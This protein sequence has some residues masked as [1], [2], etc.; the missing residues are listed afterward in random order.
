MAVRLYLED[1]YLQSFEARI[2]ASR[3][4]G[5][6]WEVALD[7]TCFYPEGGGQPCDLGTLGQAPV[8]NVYEESGCIWH[9]IDGAPPVGRV[10]GRIDWRRRFDHM[11]QHSGQ[12]LLSAVA[13]DRFGAQTLS[14]HLGAESSTID[15]DLQ[16]LTE[17]QCQAIEDDVNQLVVGNIPVRAY[18]VAPE[19]VPSLNL[20]KQPTRGEQT[21]IVEVPGVE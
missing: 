7:R 17:E 9:A 1:P 5:S 15:L 2:E 20:R 18:F 8:L 11:Q 14:F 4:G 13:L 6:G 16:D 21:R 3:Q 10:A 12:H 19:E